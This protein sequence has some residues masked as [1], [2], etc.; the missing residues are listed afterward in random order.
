MEKTVEVNEQVSALLHKISS[1]MKE[2][3]HPPLDVLTPRQSREYYKIART[4]FP[5]IPVQGVET[6]DASIRASQGHSI[7]VRIYTPSGRGNLPVL[8]YFHGGGWVFGDIDS[9][10]SACRYL[11]SHSEIIVV[12]VGYRL[13]PEHKFPAAYEDALESVLEVRRQWPDAP[14]Y[15]GGESSGGNL[16]AAVSGYYKGSREVSIQGQLLITPVLNYDFSTDSYQEN[17]R[18]NLTT[19]KMKWFFNHYLNNEEEGGKVEVSPL[20]R[21]DKQGLPE[22]VLV[23]AHFDPLREE[24]A[25]YHRQLQEAGVRAE[26]LHFEDLVH[27]FINMAGTVDRAEQAL[28]DTAASLKTMVHPNVHAD[29]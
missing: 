24:A 1:R 22:T 17:F 14:L 3:H 4:Y 12:S 13:A 26:R 20:R 6:T 8:V 23:T 19:E 29:R 9:A 7:P 5:E 10:D 21:E 11:A 16:A 25:A 28:A 2:L 15:V 27:S 18:Y